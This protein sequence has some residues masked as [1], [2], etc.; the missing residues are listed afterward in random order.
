MA[1][2]GWLAVGVATAV[3]LKRPHPE[4]LTQLNV[5]GGGRLHPPAGQPELGKAVEGKQVHPEPG[6]QLLACQ[7]VAHVRETQPRRD[8]NGTGQGGQRYG[9][10]NAVAARC[11]R[12]VL[13]R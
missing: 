7:M 8:T 9:L 1:R 5:E 6:Q 3:K 11:A 10:G 12:T 13:A 4:A 2:R